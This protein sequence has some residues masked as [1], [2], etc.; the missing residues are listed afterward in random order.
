MLA[1]D[2]HLVADIRAASRLLVRE[3]GF[4]NKTIA[5]T[6]LSPSTVHAVM[7]IGFA[8]KVSARQLSDILLLEKSTVSRLLG[9]LLQKGLV[10]ESRSGADR[11]VKLLS[12]TAKGERL[13]AAITAFAERQV[14]AALRPLSQPERQRVLAGLETYAGA[15]TAARCGEVAF[16]APAAL[17]LQT[18]YVPGII[19]AVATLHARHYSA[20]VGF[21]A[22]FEAKVAR[23]IAEFVGRLERPQ[24]QLW[25]AHKNGRVVAAIAIDGEDLGEARAHLRWFIVEPGLRGAGLGGRLI[26]AAL[27]FCDQKGFA[28]THLWTLTGLDAARLLYERHGFRLA[29][30]FTGGQWG[31]AACEQRWVRH[32][33]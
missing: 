6:G 26:A 7:E 21:G 24:N 33:H 9:P 19:G 20:L 1:T 25:Y 28:E 13:F 32:A 10:R 8:G 17:D 2:S 5:G 22:A 29:E 4:L 12:L 15:L 18:G 11:R 23:D 31:K 16:P 27:R 3:L 30:E 14:E